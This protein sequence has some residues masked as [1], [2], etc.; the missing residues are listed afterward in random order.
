MKRLFIALLVCVYI[1]TSVFSAVLPVRSSA[2]ENVGEI[3][4]FSTDTEFEI[5]DAPVEDTTPAETTAPTEPS[6][7]VATTA[8][9]ENTESVDWE[10]SVQQEEIVAAEE[11]EDELTS[12]WMDYIDFTTCQME[13]VFA[14]PGMYVGYEAVFD[15]IWSNFQYAADPTTAI[16]AEADNLISW[17]EVQG[18]QGTGARVRI[19]G[20]AVDGEGKVWF[21]VEE[22][23]GEELPEI[24]KEN[25]YILHI[26][27][28]NDTPSLIILPQKGMF[29]GETVELLRAPMAGSDSI[30]VPVTDLP[31]FFDVMYVDDNWYDVGN[32][33]GARVQNG[34]EYRFVACK[35]VLMVAPEVSHGY[36]ML[37][38]ADSSQEYG[39][40]WQGLAEGTRGEFTEAHLEDLEAHQEYLKKKEYEALMKELEFSVVTDPTEETDP[41]V[42]TDAPEFS[43]VTDPTENTEPT[44]NVEWDVMAE[45]DETNPEEDTSALAWMSYDDYTAEQT[46][47]IYANPGL[48]VG[49]EAVFDLAWDAFQYAAD[50][51]S[52]IPGPDVNLI[53]DQ[54]VVDDQ[55]NALRVKITDYVVDAENQIWYKIEG[56]EGVTLPEI[57]RE[58]PYILHLSEEIPEPSLIIQPQKGMFVGEAV[59]ISKEAAMASRYETVNTGEV[60]AFFDVIPLLDTHGQYWYDLGDV[61]G[62][63]ETLTEGYRYVSEA[64][65]MLIPPE[66]TV[67]YERLMNAASA[68]EYLEI[69]NSLPESIRSKFTEKHQA[70]LVEREE[71]FEDT[72][73][74]AVV[75][76]NGVALNVSVTGRMPLR[77]VT[78]QVSPVSN[79]TVMREG[80]DIRRGEDII[81]ALD[82]KLVKEDGSEW[83]P[84]S[85][86]QVTI[87]IDVAGLGVADESIVRL[88]HKHGE[89]IYTFD[90]FIVL[91]GKV[92]VTTNGFSTFAVTAPES[93][94]RAENAT[95][96]NNNVAI[97]MEVGEEKVFYVDVRNNPNNP[98]N[99]VGTWQV[100]DTSGAIFYEVYSAEEPNY[101]A[102]IYVP[103]IRIVALK[104]ATNVTISF[105]YA[106]IRNTSNNVSWQTETHPIRITPP[107]P[108]DGRALYLKDDV[109]TNGLITATLVRGDGTEITNGL[110]GAVFTWVRSDNKLIVPN[111]YENN[112]QSVNVAK[113]HSGLV[114]ARKKD[115]EYNPVT[116][117]VT[118]IL[119]D[120]TQ[121]TAQYTV[122]YQS[123][124]LN[125]SFESPGLAA[126]NNYT[127]YPN[128]WA[129]LIWK[130]TAPGTRGNLMRDIEYGSTTGSGTDFGVRQAAEGTQFAEL[131][132]EE[133]GALY[134]DIISVPGEELEWDFSHAP[135]RR[136]NW[137]SGT[138]GNKMFIVIGPT[139]KA[140]EL[141][142]QQQLEELG[143]AAKNAASA[144][145]QAFNNQF[146]SGAVP[147]TVNYGDAT[148]SVWYHDAGAPGQNETCYW[149]KISGSYLVPDEQYRTRLF[150]VTDSTGNDNKNFGNLIDSARAGNYKTYL[151]EYY[152]Q[153]YV[154]GEL[155]TKR[156]V[157]EDTGKPYDESGEA[158]IYSDVK[159]NNYKKLIE[160]EGD[161]LYKILVNDATYPYDLYYDTRNPEQAYLY[162]QKYSGTPIDY[163]EDTNRTYEQYDIVLQVFLRDTVVAV[164]KE[165]EFP[166]TLS[167][168]HKLQI[169]E[170]LK[171]TEDQGYKASFS[172][173]PVDGGNVTNPDASVVLA[174][175]DPAGKYTG[176]VALGENPELEHSYLV[177]ETSTTE[178]PGLVLESVTFGVKRY[179][180]GKYKDTLDPI[181]YDETQI[182]GDGKLVSSAIRLEGNIKIADVTVVNQYKEKETTIYYKAIGNGKVA[183]DVT[184]GPD[185]GFE[186]TPTEKLLYYSGQAKGAE[187][188]EGNGATFKGWYKD[189]ACTQPVESI[190]GVW[191]RSTNSFKPN[192][193]ILNADEVTFYAKFITNSIVINRTNG[194]PG[195]S[196]VYH[197]SGTTEKGQNVDLYV[198]VTCDEKGNGSKEILEVLNGSYTIT[199]VDE[200]SWRYEGD[201]Q[202]VT[203]L[204]E[205]A[206]EYKVGF[207]KG[208]DEPKWLNGLDLVKNVF[209]GSA[210]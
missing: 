162:V 208:M 133:F 166:D 146:L 119:A 107:K 48:Y 172:L 46:Q 70:A 177:E 33:G 34:V 161:Y 31:T 189:E 99:W 136:Q 178:I 87:A 65:V 96:Y 58:N 91:D 82:I 188:H 2:E 117:T 40:I 59:N 115:G 202:N 61:T 11:P 84:D 92:T 30:Q 68:K 44:E 205:N 56:A 62:W 75:E 23:E 1:A 175:R 35:S 12:A 39:E 116:Y 194:E 73:H 74:S 174:D 86:E 4:E 88:H 131:N 105:N 18:T 149:T 200:W 80:F 47:K 203:V 13:K 69:W 157:D 89:E 170:D 209:G 111:A 45:Q 81:T 210:Q 153:S 160:K 125:A 77:G 182:T 32:T 72:E 5:F 94:Q 104:E 144:Q 50:P 29:I 197:V 169:M 78:L 138:T 122:H 71:Q 158:L 140:Q 196:F 54:G 176:F 109:N 123:E 49:Y 186:D 124:I 42:A 114:E 118:A 154:L 52:T 145:G 113:D 206:Q 10:I 143:T 16:P 95:T 112:Y 8:P 120:G 6:A 126:A 184:A 130:T 152:E 97:E 192:A 67:A 187:I 207:G 27:D 43:V 106:E 22:M 37:M 85:G 135:R 165:L 180:L 171:K 93:T 141:T 198:T 36:E 142:T 79:E 103:W 147:V 132:A 100:T 199:E 163:D 139:E 66:V 128:G 159:L 179:E 3:I 129:N 41:T 20:Y 191:D 76:Y 156:L 102:G 190:D 204:G 167:E 63:N 195:Q 183:L 26:A 83:Q 28:I 64:D 24:L 193:N 164:Q 55:G 15:M 151:I 19:V 134:Q 90:V 7:P 57:L 17:E 38:D 168:V 25:P 53:T 60:P 148:Y 201:T 173:I 14:D 121:E 181:S 155:V 108:A 137:S 101:N 150:F 98:G 21:E 110:D 51:A 185:E 9:A 127:F